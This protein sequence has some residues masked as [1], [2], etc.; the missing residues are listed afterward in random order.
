MSCSNH[1]V[2]DTANF[3]NTF[4]HNYSR[5]YF[6]FIGKSISI[7]AMKPVRLGNY[8]CVQFSNLLHIHTKGRLQSYKD[9]KFCMAECCRD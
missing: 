2:E 7:P 5:M 9:V 6:V 1:D 4:E 3:Q 8:V